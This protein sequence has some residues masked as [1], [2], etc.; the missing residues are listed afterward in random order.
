MRYL[1]LLA[2]A[3]STVLELF[4]YP[5]QNLEDM[6]LGDLHQT[7]VDRFNPLKNIPVLLK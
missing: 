1:E 6:V 3:A 2:Y 4:G 5:K 7:T